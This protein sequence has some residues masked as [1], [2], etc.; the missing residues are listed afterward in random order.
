M[1]KK[2]GKGGGARKYGRNK[3][4]K[5]SPTSAFARGV[6]SGESYLKQ[7]GL[8]THHAYIRSTTRVSGL[9]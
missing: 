6:I 5:D 2:E 1:A 9:S 7:K 3:K 8:T 4:A